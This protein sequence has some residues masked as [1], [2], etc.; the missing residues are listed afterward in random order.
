MFC[1]SAWYL[2]M[3]CLCVGTLGGSGQLNRLVCHV[4]DS[5]VLC[6]SAC[7]M[8]VRVCPYAMLYVCA[9]MSVCNDVLC[10]SAC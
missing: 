6:I 4:K 10:I 3:L 2:C 5:D 7:C 8:C 9:C 1:I